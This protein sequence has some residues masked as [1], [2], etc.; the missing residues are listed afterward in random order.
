VRV[1]G[2]KRVGIVSFSHVTFY[3]PSVAELDRFTANSTTTLGV[4]LTGSVALTATLENIYDSDAR[5]R[6]ARRNSDG[7]FAFGIRASF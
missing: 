2:R 1:R 5:S 6:G 4:D 7:Q 3:Q